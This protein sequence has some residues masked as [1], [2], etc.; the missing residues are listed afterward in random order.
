MVTIPH[1][2]EGMFVILLHL[3]PCRPLLVRCEW[4]E[5]VPSLRSPAALHL[6]TLPSRHAGSMKLLT[7]STA[8]LVTVVALGRFYLSNYI[9]NEARESPVSP[10]WR[11]LDQGF[12]EAAAC[13]PLQHGPGPHRPRR[14]LLSQPGHPFCQR[15]SQLH[16]PANWALRTL[17]A[18]VAS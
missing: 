8:L 7:L 14:A 17:S 16:F 3:R 10:A 1:L 13:I 18:R 9:F 11:R 6:S 15:L 12:A 2:Q 4:C 5:G